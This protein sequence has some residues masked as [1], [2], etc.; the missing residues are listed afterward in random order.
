MKL[1]RHVVVSVIVASL[2]ATQ[3][4]TWTSIAQAEPVSPEASQP[5]DPFAQAGRPANVPANYVVTPGGYR[6]PSCV[7]VVTEQQMVVN[8]GNR[9]VLVDI[10]ANGQVTDSDI[11]QGTVLPNCAYPTYDSLGNVVTYRGAEATTSPVAAGPANAVVPPADGATSSAQPASVG[12]MSP[13]RAMM[14]LIQGLLRALASMLGIA[15]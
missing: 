6:D 2:A 7:H 3:A 14:A 8:D 10:P 13:L 12:V 5:G 1:R 15:W 9:V 4:A 11:A